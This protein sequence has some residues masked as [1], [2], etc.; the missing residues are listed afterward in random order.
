MPDDNDALTEAEEQAEQERL[1]R[2]ALEAAGID[3]RQQPPAAAAPTPPPRPQE[4][5]PL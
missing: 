5:R 4:Q 2:A 1:K 3:P